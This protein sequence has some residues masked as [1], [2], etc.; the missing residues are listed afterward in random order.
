MAATA[1]LQQQVW[2]SDGNNR[3]AMCSPSGFSAWDPLE[4]RRDTAA[5][6]WDSLVCSLLN[7]AG[8]RRVFHT[9]FIIQM[10]M[11][12]HIHS[13]R[14]GFLHFARKAEL[15]CLSGENARYDNKNITQGRLLTSD[16][17]KLFVQ[18]SVQ[19]FLP[20]FPMWLVSKSLQ[21]G[22]ERNDLH[23]LSSGLTFHYIEWHLKSVLIGWYF[24][25]FIIL[26]TQ[27]QYLGPRVWK[28]LCTVSQTSP[29][30][31]CF[32]AKPAFLLG[33]RRTGKN[34]MAACPPSTHWP[35]DGHILTS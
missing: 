6:F 32:S 28:M 16:V 35:Q 8:V 14:G 9:R 26:R 5:F 30:L 33:S 21:Q 27:Y 4:S 12:L 23:S 2:R 34:R 3:P 24:I 25:H 19:H 13:N 7:L 18:E 22:N 1:P 29:P 15:L 10:Q 31:N 20:K 11:K 17:S